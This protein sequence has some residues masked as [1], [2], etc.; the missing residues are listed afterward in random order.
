[1]INILGGPGKEF[2]PIMS[3]D[4]KIV[5]IPFVC[6]DGSLSDEALVFIQ[7]ELLQ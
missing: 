6:Q 4:R 5:E 2:R 3:S 1:V 7:E